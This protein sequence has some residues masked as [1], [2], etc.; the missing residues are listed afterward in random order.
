[1]LLS[2]PVPRITNQVYTGRVSTNT[3]TAKSA[4]TAR[5]ATFSG[6]HIDGLI[7]YRDDVTGSR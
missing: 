3:G 1:M 2:S 7:R 5:T 6:S 4:N